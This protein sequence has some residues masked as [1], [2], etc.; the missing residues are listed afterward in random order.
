MEKRRYSYGASIRESV[1]IIHQ[2][3]QI[4]YAHATYFS[5]SFMNFPD[6]KRLTNNHASTEIRF[7][8]R[9]IIHNAISE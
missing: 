5:V 8:L 9:N 4:L 3:K 1:Y 6:F 7:N 2:Y